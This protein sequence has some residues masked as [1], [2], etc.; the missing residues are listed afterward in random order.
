MR[1]HRGLRAAR[2]GCDDMEMP[3]IEPGASRMQSERSTTELHPQPPT[4]LNAP[5]PIPFP[6][7]RLSAPPLPLFTSSAGRTSP[8]AALFHPPIHTHLSPKHLCDRT[9]KQ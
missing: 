7:I 4:V 5:P 3:G 6:S 1:T 9:E 2:K 8:P